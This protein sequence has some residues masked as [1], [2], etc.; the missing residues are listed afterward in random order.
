M[1][2]LKEKQH[3]DEIQHYKQACDGKKSYPYLKLHFDIKA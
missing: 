1:Q 2:Q 3:S